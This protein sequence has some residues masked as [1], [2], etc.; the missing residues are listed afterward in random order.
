M[1]QAPRERLNHLLDLAAQGPAGRAAL[2]GELADLLLDWPADY[3]LAMRAPFEALMEKTA[4]EVDAQTRMDVARRLEGHAELPVA[5]L[6]EFFLEAPH[7]LRARILALNDVMDA[8]ANDTVA[9]DAAQLL[10][11]ARTMNGTFCSAFAK[12]LALPETTSREILGDA[13]GECLA[14][15][16]KGA[17][18]DR[19]AF[20]AIT[21]LVRRDG[22]VDARLCAFDNVPQNAAERLTGFWRARG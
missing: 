20:S 16:C 13:S 7:G 6:N 22:D 4:R 15:A 18:L 21:V 12:L 9:V 11:A 1:A 17:G 5:V 14:V 19:A 10:E 3:A 8:E 2:L